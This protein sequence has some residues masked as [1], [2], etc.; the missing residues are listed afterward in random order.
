MGMAGADGG[1]EGLKKRGRG[2]RGGG[3]VEGV[4]LGVVVCAFLF[5]TMVVVRLS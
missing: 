1:E 5:D 2:K 3:E 4:S